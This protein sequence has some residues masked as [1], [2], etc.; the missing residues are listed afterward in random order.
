MGEQ[1]TVLILS[2]NEF[3]QCDACMDILK[4]GEKVHLYMDVNNQ[5]VETLCTA[6]WEIEVRER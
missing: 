3:L 2:E 6:C 5:L 1:W 4:E